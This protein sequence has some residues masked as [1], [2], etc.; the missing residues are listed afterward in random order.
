[1]TQDI[2]KWLEKQ[3]AFLS[4]PKFILQQNI[5]VN[6][7][8]YYLK[9]VKKIGNDLIADYELFPNF[10]IIRF[11]KYDNGWRYISSCIKKN[12]EWVNG[13]DIVSVL[14]YIATVIFNNQMYNDSRTFFIEFDEEYNFS[15]TLEERIVKLIEKF[16]TQPDVFVEKDGHFPKYL[17]SSNYLLYSEYN[18]REE[19]KIN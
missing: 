5:A 9:D 16:E 7:Y 18:D 4:P 3:T 11:R 10:L 17:L 6:P 12:G 1:M 15:K 8:K 19:M 14:S 13:N 2:L